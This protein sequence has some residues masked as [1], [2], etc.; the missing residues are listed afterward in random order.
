[1]TQQTLCGGHRVRIVQQA[2]NYIR[3][4]RP[5]FRCHHIISRLSR[6]VAWHNRLSTIAVSVFVCVFTIVS[7]TIVSAS[8]L[9]ELKQ[10]TISQS[11]EKQ[12]KITQVINHLI[13]Q[14]HFRK[15]PIDDRFSEK[16]LNRFVNQLDPAKRFFL[17][18]D[19]DQFHTLKYAFDDYIKRGIMEPVYTIFKT[20]KMRVT[21]RIEHALQR[22]EEP[23]DFTL[24]EQFLL[25]AKEAR[26]AQDEQELNDYWR[27]RIKNDIINLHLAKVS[28]DSSD[29]DPDKH[30]IKT[31]SNRYINIARRTLQFNT[32]DVFKNFINAYVTT[33]E[34]HTSYYSP[35]GAENFRINMRLSLDGIGAVLQI[36]DEHT[37]VRRVISGG[38]ADIAGD[39]QAEDRIIGVGQENKDIVDIVGWRLSDV[40][41]LIR[42]KKG[43]TVKLRILPGEHGLNAKPEIIAIVRDKI[44][45]EQQAAKKRLLHVE[46]KQSKSTIGV[47][48]L[49]SFYH[50]FGGRSND[51][52]YRSTTKDVKKL[53]LELKEE[54]IDGLVI[55]I[56]GNGGGALVEA[57][58]LTGLFIPEGPVVQVKS[59]GGTV[60]VNRDVYPE[61]VYDGPLVVLVDRY[62]ASASEI[63]AG[64]IQDYNRGLIIGEPTFGKGTVQNLVALNRYVKDEKDLGQLKLTIAQFFRINGDSTQHRGVTP[65]I[66]WHTA[67]KEVSSGERS[68]ENAVPWQHI[69]AVSFVPF[70][71][72]LSTHVLSQTLSKHTSR[73]TEN[74][75]FDYLL[76]V[77]Q[78]NKLNRNKQFVTLNQN[79]RYEN[80]QQQDLNFLAV[81]N[82]KQTALGKPVFETIDLF[83][84]DQKE[85]NKKAEDKNF[86]EREADIFLAE[87]GKILTDIIHY[88]NLP[89]DNLSEAELVGKPSGSTKQLNN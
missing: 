67:D 68:F 41:A 70:Q 61:V 29:D 57:V 83:N 18:K 20:Y 35:R 71:S 15:V 82:K 59:S 79:K 21:Q 1:M 39:L 85:R 6:R 87:S 2:T 63:F 60:E 24:E 13:D 40:V 17:Q 22:I 42:G 32:D 25:T 69:D 44:N 19:I 4:R 38:P 14:S 76:A 8:A 46:T 77:D 75:E 86:S 26:W 12:S 34:P 28:D 62:S 51:P 16:V 84:A 64:A 9:S 33:I 65:D 55:D 49:P 52:D 31:L 47:I 53:L 56:R 43:S 5:A 36:K 10:S 88:K 30:I 23:F 81:V 72:P 78:I 27:K 58:S 45:L 11:F 37:L 74:P 54:N 73:V 66:T 48:D 50:D 7:P 89:T 3:T 80:R